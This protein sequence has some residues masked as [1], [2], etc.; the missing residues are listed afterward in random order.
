MLL[1]SVAPFFGA[2]GTACAVVFT[3][4]YNDLNED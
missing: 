4:N 2:L 1:I 3:S